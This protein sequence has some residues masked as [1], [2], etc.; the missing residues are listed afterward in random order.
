MKANAVHIYE[1]KNFSDQTFVL[2]ECVFNNCTLKNCDLFYSGGDFEF[3]NLKAENCR[4]HW[5]GGAKN[6]ALLFQT[7]GML[8][9]PSQ[10]PPQVKM[11]SQKPN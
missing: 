6:T 8:R 10:I 2:E 1:D 7:I 3:V 9:E 4:F 11:T 5:R